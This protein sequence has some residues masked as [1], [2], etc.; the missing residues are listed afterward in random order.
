MPNFENYIFENNN[1]LDL[2]LYQYG[3]EDCLPYQMYGP[4]MRNHYLLHFVLK[5]QG[6]YQLNGTIYPIKTGQAF[7]IV[8]HIPTTYYADQKNP[9]SY[10]WIEFDGIKAAE[11]LKCAGLSVKNTIYIPR[12]KEIK[13]IPSA[14]DYLM[15]ILTHHNESE[16]YQISY[17]YL[18]F[19]SLIKYSKED[20]QRRPGTLKEFYMKEAVHYIEA[21]YA[22]GISVEDIATWC[23]LNRTYFSK[24]FKDSL[25]ITPQEFLLKYRMMKACDLL[26]KSSLPINEIAA[27][28]GYSNALNFSRAFR[29]QYNMPPRTWRST[30][31]LSAL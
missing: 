30:H 29:K 3:K 11:L 8:P 28:V 13:G 14:P 16:L 5:G 7:L 26:S 6:Y 20:S 2:T 12:F 25:K 24:L 22:E 18:M 31:K 9:W 1:L 10:I 19:D 4:V 17:L 21:H 23:N 27:L 15:H